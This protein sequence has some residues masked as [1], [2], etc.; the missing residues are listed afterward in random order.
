M[1]E[2]ISSQFDIWNKKNFFVLNDL[3]FAML[4]NS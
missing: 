4:M 1:R 3:D 2:I